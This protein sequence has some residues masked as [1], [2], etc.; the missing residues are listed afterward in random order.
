MEGITNEP[1]N[2][3]DPVE[4]SGNILFGNSS[5]PDLHFY[6]ANI[7]NLNTPYILPKELQ[8]ILGDDKGENVSVLHLNSKSI[9]KYFE[10]LKCFYR[11]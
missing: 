2:K 8:I 5:D 10:I 1:I 11:I 3:Y 7:Q 6:N 9:N 4:N